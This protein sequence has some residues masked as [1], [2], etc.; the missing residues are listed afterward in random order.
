MTRTKPRSPLLSTVIAL[1]VGVFGVVVLGW[2]G[3]WQLQRLAWKEAILTEIE[4]RIAA[5]PRP[6]PET[7]DPERDRYLPVEVTGTIGAE[8]ILILASVK[9]VGAV[10]RVLGVLTTD[11]GRRILIDR[12]VRPFGDPLPDEGEITGT[13]TGNLHWPDELNK[14]TPERDESGLWFARDVPTLSEVYG[15]EPTLLVLRHAE[16]ASATVTPLPVSTQGIP[17]DHLG[18][19]VQWFGLAL[20]WAGMTVYFLWSIRRRKQIPAGRRTDTDPGAAA[21]APSDAE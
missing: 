14:Y 11:D 3:T 15:T 7:F 9:E 21:P 12:G 19:A 1:V 13:F 20:V 6:L 18:Y 4:T 2:L 5:D 16:P 10:H 8:P 17:N